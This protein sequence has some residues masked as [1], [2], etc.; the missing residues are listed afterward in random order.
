L[1][2]TEYQNDAFDIRMGQKMGMFDKDEDDYD[3][4]KRK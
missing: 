3:V 2:N 1:N 4:T